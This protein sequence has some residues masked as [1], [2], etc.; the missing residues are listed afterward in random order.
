MIELSDV[1]IEKLLSELNE[2][3]STIGFLGYASA[4]DAIC[5]FLDRNKHIRMNANVSS[6]IAMSEG[7]NDY[8][9]KA[10]EKHFH[11]SCISRYSN[12]ENGM[13]AQQM[14]GITNEF[15]INFASYYVELLNLENN[16]TCSLGKPGRIVVT[17]FYNKAMPLIRY[18]T[19]DIGTMGER[20]MNG[21]KFPVLEK[22]EGRKMDM[23]F[24]S[25][26]DLVSSFTITNGMWKYTELNQYQFIQK[27]KKEYHFKLNCDQPF[28][29]NLN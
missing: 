12:V 28:K 29:E 4:Y 19:G 2:D 23:V 17:D 14:P 26:G 1:A 13:I 11:C 9:K 18:D 16:N 7:L 3:H 21:K 6:A 15:Y 20:I 27:G 10:M 5:K 25:N 22:I 24:N 8:T